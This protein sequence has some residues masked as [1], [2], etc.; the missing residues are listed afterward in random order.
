MNL[1]V[2]TDDTLYMLLLLS[3]AFKIR[4]L[5][6]DFGSLIM[7]Y[8]GLDLFEFIL[9]VLSFLNV[10]MVFHQ[11]WKV[12]NNYFFKYSF[13]YFLCLLSF[14]NF[15]YCI[16]LGTINVFPQISKALFIFLHSLVLNSLGWIISIDFFSSPLIVFYSVSSKWISNTSSEILIS[17]IALF[18]SRS[19]TWL[20]FHNFYLFIDIC[21]SMTHHSHTFP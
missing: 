13:C 1:N 8:L 12:L 3:C 2:V 10:Q 7:I 14:W 21:Y 20:I 18:K 19:S 11:I 4:F 6:L 16:Y 15:H 9:L 5:S 17:V